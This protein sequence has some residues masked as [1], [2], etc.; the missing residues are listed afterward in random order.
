MTIRFGTDG[1]RGVMV[2]EFTF[3]AVQSLARA[4]AGHL[5]TSGIAGRGCAVGYDGR[6]LS[7]RF[8]E[9]AADTLARHGVRVRLADR[10][11]PTPAISLAVRR[12]GAACGLMIT[13][14][15]NPAPYNGVKLKAPHGGPADDR[16][17]GAVLRRLKREDE[18]LPLRG[19]RGTVE[20][21]NP[22]PAYI[23]ALRR[24]VDTESIVRRGLRVTYD[25]MH[26]V[27]GQVLAE[28]LG[29]GQR[30]GFLRQELRPDFG[31]GVPEPVERHLGGLIARVKAGEADVGLAGDGDADRLGVV[32]PELGYVDAQVVFALLVRRRLD[33]VGHRGVAATVTTT[34]RACLL[35]EAGG[36]PFYQTPVGFKHISPL[37]HAGRATTGG[38]E[39]GGYGFAEHLPERDGLVSALKVLELLAASGVRLPGLIRR[40]DV[41]LGP[42]C[43]LRRDLPLADDAVSALRRHLPAGPACLP[44]LPVPIQRVERDDGLKFWVGRRGRRPE[45]WVMV[46][47]SGTEPL[48]RLYAE[49]TD[50]QLTRATLA[51]AAAWVEW[52]VRE[53][54]FE[55]RAAGSARPTGATRAP[56]DD[57]VAA[58]HPCG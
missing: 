52:L 50:P 24:A 13:A 33:L 35:A 11:S 30:I 14:S 26:G 49:T 10:P 18:G 1:W 27:A 6:S 32:D 55:G 53:P 46:R 20:R 21:F 45:G 9:A 28:V 22:L 47:A 25:A 2:S 16:F 54:G 43:Y 37:L 38:E 36:V 51:A 5:I 57:R 17:T 7:D 19:R 42:C 8:A 58:S 3:G 48:L 4:L 15:H 39:S 34:C 56:S 41:A 23:R 31:G 44:A 40:L 29:P 12:Q